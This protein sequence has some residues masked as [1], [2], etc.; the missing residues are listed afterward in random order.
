[1]EIEWKEGEPR[2]IVLSH[3]RRNCPCALC[4]EGRQN[5][6]GDSG[7]YMITAA[8]MAATDEVL[9]VHPVGRYAIQIKWSDGHDTGIYT[10][11]YLRQLIDKL[12]EAAPEP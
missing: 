1:M 8:E 12:G 4:V 9:A 5:Q 11:D 10:F 3:L 2:R 7:L 6:A